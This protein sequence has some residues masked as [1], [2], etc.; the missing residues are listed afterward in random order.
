MREY[1]IAFNGSWFHF[2]IK[3][4]V[5]L[6]SRKKS[7][8]K[9]EDYRVLI[10]GAA[11][12]FCVY[13][14][15]S[16][17][18]LVCQDEKGSVLYLLYDGTAWKKSIILESRTA[19]PY[20]KN[21]VITEISGHI[22]L[23]YTIENKDKLMLVH[24][25]LIGNRPPN[26]VGYVTPGII[27]FCIY[28][29]HETDFSVF[30]TNEHGDTCRRIYQWSKKQ[31]LEPEILEKNISI[32]FVTEVSSE[33]AL[34]AVKK[35]DNSNN[36]IFMKEPTENS[37]ME[38]VVYP[39]CSKEI[40]PIISRYGEKTYMVWTEHGNVMSSCFISDTEWSKPMQYAKSSKSETKLY[41][42]CIDGKYEYFYGIGREH[43]ITLY[44]TH[45]ILK[46]QPKTSPQ[47]KKIVSERISTENLLL[48]QEKQIKKLC[49]ELSEQ[50]KKLSELSSK[51]EEL[52][53][54]VPIADE[55][56]IDNVL[57]N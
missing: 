36:L 12:D 35:T 47:H 21:F 5:G 34:A 28:R 14:S 37:G 27:P 24:Q 40:V 49:Y 7:G 56:D 30:Y 33:M 53:S 8:L 4:H 13:T 38:P 50:R 32:K 41:A 25:I 15:D 45:D 44:G 39:N 26:I 51:I 54:S 6:C 52:L 20:V 42:I 48:N 16:Q 55:D 31:F 29:H 9:F 19:R 10:S 18:H 11:S 17:I 22:N 3:P 2:F 57:L 23:L 46:T 1:I 43:D